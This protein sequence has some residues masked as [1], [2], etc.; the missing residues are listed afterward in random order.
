MRR[1]ALALAAALLAVAMAACGDDEGTKDASG[2][3]MGSTFEATA[4][5]PYTF[6]YPSEWMIGDEVEGD[7]AIGIEGS[8]G[9][10]LEPV[11]P[12]EGPGSFGQDGERVEI[13]G[14]E[15]YRMP[16]EG[17]EEGKGLAYRVNADGTAA[18]VWFF[19]TDPAAYDEALFEAI[20]GTFHVDRQL[21]GS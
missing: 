12:W 17:G 21:L 15:A 8:V 2:Y 20:M 11:H 7:L 4:E 6:S 3:A 19:A 18:T 16:L 1:V 10:V 13:D 5:R 14:F 9:M